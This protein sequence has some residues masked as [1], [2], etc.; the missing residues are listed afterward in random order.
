[1]ITK[2]N[3]LLLIDSLDRDIISLSA[4]VKELE[5]NSKKAQPRDK[6]GKFSKKK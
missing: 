5:K 6:S 4:R 2:R 3:L 1:M